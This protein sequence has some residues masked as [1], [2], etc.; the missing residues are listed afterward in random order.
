MLWIIRL[1][2]I[3]LV[4]FMD[5]YNEVQLNMIGGMLLKKIKILSTENFDLLTRENYG[6]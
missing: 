1:I 6:S 3:G 2:H 5:Q 4:Q